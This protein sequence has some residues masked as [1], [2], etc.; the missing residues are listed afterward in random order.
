MQR[1]GTRKPPSG[2]NTARCLS[3]Q[4]VAGEALAEFAA[5]QHLV[6][7]VVFDARLQRAF[8]DPTIGRAASIEPVDMKSCSPVRRSISLPQLVGAAQQ[9]HVGGMLVVGQAD[10]ACVAV[11]RA[12][13]VRD[14]EPLDAQHA[15]AALGELIAGRAAHAADADDDGVVVFAVAGHKLL[16]PPTLDGRLRGR[17]AF[18]P[19]WPRC[20]QADALRVEEGRRGD[21]GDG[22]AG[23]R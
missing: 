12:H 22:W 8:E 6:G 16:S 18:D 1:S 10:D 15:F 13:I 19:P 17:F 20:P 5:G 3:R 7:Q 11:G 14:V 23:R 21:C 9:H 2:W 4:P